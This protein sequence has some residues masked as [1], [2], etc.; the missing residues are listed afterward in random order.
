[1]TPSSGL[2]SA[3]AAS[4]T[5][6][7]TL[8]SAFLQVPSISGH[9]GEFTRRVAD[10]A[11]GHGF[12]VDLWQADEAGLAPFLTAAGM[13]GCRHLPL[14][15]RPTLVIRLPGTGHGRSLLFNAHADVVSAGDE[16][17]WT[18][19]AWSGHDDG[20]RIFGR[21]ACDV[22]GPLVSALWAM[23]L[24]AKPE[25][26][27][28]GDVLLELIPGEE[29]CVGLGTLTSIARGYRA[30][31]WVVLE[32]T[33]GQPRCASRGGMRFEVTAT[34]QAVHGTVK[35]LG[36]DAIALSRRVLE[37]LERLEARWNDKSADPLFS[38]Y[39]LARS[40]TVDS[41]HGGVWQ[42]MVCDR[43][44]VAG[45]LELLPDD[46]LVMWADKFTKDL[47]VEL[48]ADAAAISVR[49]SERYRGHR[50]KEGEPF[51]QTAVPA[52]G[53]QVSWQ[54][55]NS[56]CEAGMRPLLEKVPTLVWGPGSLAQAH[57]A[58]E[59]VRWDDVRDVTARFVHLATAWCRQD[60]GGA[61]AG[62]DSV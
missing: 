21:G 5:G 45:Y 58:D 31:G 8:L 19:G 17:T 25:N 22:K 10:W 6:M 40:V 60:A 26:R 38:S 1:M 7:R 29:D 27:V 46:G 24:L 20:G 39:P 9:E 57:A 33:E 13:E 11:K 51:D 36:K 12:E 52:C 47:K 16:S 3:L 34:G 35:W 59:Y 50:N 30:D 44:V 49:F 42:G 61:S 55:F 15:G 2:V 56:G 4:S 18:H 41:V 43:C 62:K 28:A 32:P 54:G 14:A 53:G 48:G 23:M 37:A